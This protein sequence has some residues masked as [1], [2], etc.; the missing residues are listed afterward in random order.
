[1][2]TYSEN[3]KQIFP[4]PEA[5]RLT[6]NSQNNVSQLVSR[7]GSGRANRMYDGR[8]YWRVGRQSEIIPSMDSKGMHQIWQ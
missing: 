3:P 2:G 5:I 6:S 8:L 4:Q 7:G 1:M